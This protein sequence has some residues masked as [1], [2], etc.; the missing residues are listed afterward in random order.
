MDP[1]DEIPGRVDVRRI[2]D[3]E[4]PF[5]WHAFLGDVRVNGG[6]AKDRKYAIYLGKNAIAAYRYQI[7]VET[8]VWI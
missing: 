4:W 7:W 8:H 6:L 5:Y 3:E 2:P 1:A